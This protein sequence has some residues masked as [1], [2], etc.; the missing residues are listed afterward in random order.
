MVFY[1]ENE[2]PM[3][4]QELWQTMHTK[5]FDAF[6][7]KEYNLLA[8]IELEKQISNDIMKRRVRIISKIDRNYLTRS[9]AKR[10]LGSDIL[11]YEE[12]QKKYLN[13]FELHW[14]II[15][16]VFK[17]K[18][19]ASGLLKLEPIDNSKCIRIR[20]GSLDISL[21]GANRLMEIIAAAQ[22]KK[23]KDRFCQIVE[24]WKT[25]NV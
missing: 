4:A 9:I 24:K 23:S 8:Y 12:I 11:V 14:Q 3:S 25:L 19:K 16:P 6:V 20:E 10:I 13:R 21:F 2:I 7:A 15:P 17:D 5:R 18:F 1:L 22:S